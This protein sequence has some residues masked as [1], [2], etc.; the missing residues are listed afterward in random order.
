MPNR[1]C[2]VADCDYPARARGWCSTH[3]KRWEVHGDP[4]VGGPVARRT[5]TP[6]QRFWDKVRKSDSCWEWTGFL[7]N[8]YGRVRVGERMVAVHRFSYELSRG[9]IPEGLHID[10]LCRNRACVR[11]DHLEAVTQRENTLRGYGAAAVCA[12]KTHCVNGHEF[13]E[14][15]TIERTD[16]V[17]VSSVDRRAMR[18]EH[19]P[20]RPQR[21]GPQVAE[22]VPPM[23]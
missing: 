7:H 18:G 15:N 14:E 23:R 22:R 13:N 5:R 8:G 10:H 21:D 20:A 6:E 2:S 16:G 1:T 4:N 11:P 17:A 19:K 9:P 3:Y 12:R